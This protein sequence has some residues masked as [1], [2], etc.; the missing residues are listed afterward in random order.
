M[1][2]GQPS[3]FPPKTPQPPPRLGARP[4]AAQ[5]GGVG[6]SRVALIELSCV[7]VSIVGHWPDPLELIAPT[8]SVR[9]VSEPRLG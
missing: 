2:L 8:S 9:L 3:G 7:W 1:F 6:T 5:L 4:G